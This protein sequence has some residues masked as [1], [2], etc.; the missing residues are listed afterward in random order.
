MAEQPPLDK[1]EWK[2]RPKRKP[3]PADADATTDTA[4]L[5][6]PDCEEDPTSHSTQGTESE[7]SET[8]KRAQT[9]S[10]QRQNIKR[11]L[12]E[13]RDN[14]NLAAQNLN[15]DLHA[16]SHRI[17]N[18]EQRISAVEDR[19]E[20]VS[21]DASQSSRDIS[22][23]Q[24]KLDDVKNRNCSNNLRLVGLS[25]GLE[26]G[27]IISFLDKIFSYI[28]DLNESDPC[29][30]IERAYQ[31]LRPKSCPGKPQRP[32]ILRMLHWSDSQNILSAS[33]KKGDLTWNGRCFFIFQEFL[34]RSAEETCLVYR[35]E[36]EAS[37]RGSTIWD[38]VSSKTLCDN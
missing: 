36:E 37:N 6:E 32:I 30:E 33:R 1:E 9:L 16:V 27:N 31:A 23:L 34:H 14:L 7:E 28:M 15:K 20:S 11:V 22:L 10:L 17:G 21:M 12:N 26:T 19:V 29:P 13:K 5:A 24:S 25:E 35:I 4:I 8:P 18:A 38:S 2:T 3:K